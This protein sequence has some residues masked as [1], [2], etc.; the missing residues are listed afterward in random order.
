VESIKGNTLE[1]VRIRHHEAFPTQ[2]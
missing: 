2:V 1:A